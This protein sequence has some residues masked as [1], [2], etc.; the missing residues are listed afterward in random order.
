[1]H[2]TSGGSHYVRVGSTKQIILGPRLP[3]SY[4]N[5]DRT[6]VFDG[7]PVLTSSL[8]YLDQRKLKP[9]FNNTTR[10]IP[11]SNLLH[12]TSILKSTQDGTSHATVAGLLMF[13]TCPQ[14]HLQSTSIEAAVYQGLHPTL[15][16]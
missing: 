3:R 6:L 7:L 12:N 15:M 8:E 10:V 16:I 11:W 14:N 4:Q 9:Y 5:R 1:M 2:A 13:G